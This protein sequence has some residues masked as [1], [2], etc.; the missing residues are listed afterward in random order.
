MKGLLNDKI[1]LLLQLKKYILSDS[2]E[3][4]EIQ[5]SAERK[6]GWFTREFILKSIQAI[7]DNYLDENALQLFSER[8][9]ATNQP[10]TIGVVMAGNI[11]LVGFHDFLCVFLS[12]HRLAFK[13]SSKDDVLLPAMVQYL[14]SINPDIMKEVEQK[15]MLKNCDAY[16]ATGSNHTAKV[17]KSYF[18]K[19]PHII[20]PNKTSVAVLSGQETE[21]ELSLLADDV[22]QYFGLGCRNVTKIF[23][24]DDYPFEPLLQAFRKYD[25]LKDHNKYRNNLDYQLALYILNNQYYMSNDSVLLIEH[26]SIFSAV[27][28]LHY[29]YYSNQDTLIDALQNNPNI[30]TIVGQGFTSFG[31][32][33]HPGISDFADGIDTVEFL[34]S[35]F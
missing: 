22:Y 24:P 23:V 11:P 15:E 16:L 33:Q 5:D 4:E 35:L 14:K 12:P 10:R 29:S 26:E 8:F 31:A 21:E 25:H 13:C 19:Y 18:G 30:Q 2:E 27:S 7:A 32:A 9:S 20:R 17:F 3:W 28:V 1:H 34:N 6:N